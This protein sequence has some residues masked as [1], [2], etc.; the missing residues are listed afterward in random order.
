MK[1]L[2]IRLKTAVLDVKL[3]HIL[4]GIA[5]SP[6]RCARSLVDLGKSISPKELTRIEYRLLYSE[7]LKLCASS[8]IEGTKKNFF[9]HFNPD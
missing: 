6:E 3:D 7:F 4:R 9:R 8:D 2:E 1:S 5:K